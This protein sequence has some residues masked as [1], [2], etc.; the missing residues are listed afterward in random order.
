V[1][2]RE[3]LDSGRFV[4]TAELFP[5]KGTDMGRLKEKAGLIRGVVDAVNVTDNQR[6]VMRVG[7]IAVARTL[8][9]L[10]IEPIYQLTCR[11][12]NRLA[13]QSDLLAASVLG[14]RNVLL[15]SGDHPSQGDHKDAMPVYDLDTV[16]L[17]AAAAGLVA[18]HD[19]NAK[20]LK[21]AADLFIGAA[22]NPNLEP[23][24]LQLMVMEKKIRAGA[25]FFQSQVCFDTELIE[26]YIRLARQHGAFILGSLSLFS[27]ANQMEHFRRM[28]VRIPQP[29]FDRIAGAAS[30]LAESARVCAEMMKELKGRMDGVH[31]IAINIE[32]N[33][34]LIFG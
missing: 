29:V 23:A 24:G 4:V 18:G 31:L 10:G 8:L 19:M 25:K 12:R 28:G 27:S 15:L 30:P 21:G 32:E 33:I 13:L 16:Q 26:P 3:K 5:P 1:T 22:V 14:V 20:P 2:F 17:I 34:P 9:D 11:D 7:G 6:A